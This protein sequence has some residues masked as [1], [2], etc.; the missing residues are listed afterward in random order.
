MNI[1]KLSKVISAVERLA[2]AIERLDS[3]VS[4]SAGGI[5]SL[6]SD[7]HGSSAERTKSLEAELERVGADYA[8]LREAVTSVSDRLGKSIDNLQKVAEE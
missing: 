4:D 2:I 5:G 7:E 8:R 6:T 3:A 1:Y